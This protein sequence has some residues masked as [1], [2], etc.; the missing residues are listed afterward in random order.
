MTPGC[1]SPTMA[2]K[3]Q[4]RH[5]P[6]DLEDVAG[7]LIG[8]VTIIVCKDRPPAAALRFLLTAITPC[9]PAVGSRTHRQYG[10][11]SASGRHSGFRRSSIREELQSHEGL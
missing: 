2:N 10:L 5:G 11:G 9:A 8:Q 7:V 3:L 4:R 6:F 1:V